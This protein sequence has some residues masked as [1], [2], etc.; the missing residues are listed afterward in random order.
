MSV[1]VAL[2]ALAAPSEG[3][4][5]M[6]WTPY[7]EIDSSPGL[8]GFPNA[9]TDISCPSL[10]LC[11]AVSIDG[12]IDTSTTPAETS[13]SRDERVQAEDVAER[14]GDRDVRGRPAE[15]LDR[16]PQLDHPAGA[17]AQS[18]TDVDRHANR[19]H[20]MR[21]EGTTQAERDDHDDFP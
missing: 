8:G 14:S 19:L 20:Q 6:Q 9:V 1:L 3:A 2:C 11:V 18:A 12:D 13:P 15:L 10:A 4:S 5:T 16:P 17:T 7:A 21:P